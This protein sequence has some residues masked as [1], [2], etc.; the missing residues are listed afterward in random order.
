[1]LGDDVYGS[2]QRTTDGFTDRYRGATKRKHI[3]RT[4]GGKRHRKR[5]LQGAFAHMG[6]LLTNFD[7][8]GDDLAVR[9]TL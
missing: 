9:L 5:S 3:S 2:K 4:A 7:D 6:A 8:E 1:M